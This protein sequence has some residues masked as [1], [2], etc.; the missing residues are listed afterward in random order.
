MKRKLRAELTGLASKIL[1]D[2]KM[3]ELPV[4]YEQARMLYE[5]LAVLNFIEEKL[6]DLEVDVSKSSQ[7][8]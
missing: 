2:D 5:K 7:R 1:S 8:E 6:Q 4:L 3:T